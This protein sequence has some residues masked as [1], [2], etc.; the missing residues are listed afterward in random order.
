MH[1][2]HAFLLFSLCASRS[3]SCSN[4]AMDN[5]YRLS[6]DTMDFGSVPY[7]WVIIT[8][9]Q[10]V[11]GIRSSRFGYVG[12]IGKLGSVL[13][14]KRVAD[15][16]NA[17]GLTCDS[18][19]L[20][21]TQYP[22]RNESLDNIAADYICT[23]ALEGFSSV[24]DLKAALGDVNFV[25]AS[26]PFFQGQQWIFR[27]AFGHGL[28]LEF[29]DGRMEAYDD[30]N[31]GGKTGFGILTNEPSFLWHNEAVRHLQWKQSLVRSAV[32]MPGSWY[33]EAR[34]QRLHL[35]KSGMPTPSSYQ[36][37]IMQTVHV[38]NTVTVPMGS[39]RGTDSGKGEGLGDHTQ[40]AVIY[41]SKKRIV[42]WRTQVNQNLQRL[43]LEDAG[44]EK[45]GQ[46]QVIV[47]GSLQLPW[48]NDVSK[49]LTPKSTAST[50]G[51]L[52]D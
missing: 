25:E 22:G 41:D 3:R 13:E 19:T 23:W 16:M 21:G 42:Y 48:F 35:V 51:E 2:R 12:F 27:D 11:P 47:A 18:H 30:F 36:E 33:P 52:F 46:E 10:G 17:A 50:P 37:A 34:F 29:L 24:A 1:S 40:Y 39:Q 7:Q 14:E 45:G 44:L 5:E 4:F 9:P 28:V 32:E 6:A 20:L 49:T 31:D 43:R 38:L 26:D 8:R 15:G